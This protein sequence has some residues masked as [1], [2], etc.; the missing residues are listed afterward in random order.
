MSDEDR[1][2]CPCGGRKPEKAIVC[3]PCFRTAP[4]DLR[5]AFYAGSR[6]SSK[7]TAIEALRKHAEHEGRRR[8]LLTEL[9]RS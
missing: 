5:I 8:R 7:R 3:P 2:I 1:T 4:D 6:S 9:D